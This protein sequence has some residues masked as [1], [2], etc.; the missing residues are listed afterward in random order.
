VEAALQP[1][2]LDDDYGVRAGLSEVI[3]R[4]REEG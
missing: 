2:I 3:S 1:L 4:R